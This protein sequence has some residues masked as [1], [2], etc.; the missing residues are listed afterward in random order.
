MDWFD[1]RAL[2]QSATIAGTVNIIQTG[3]Y[4][5]VGDF[6]GATYKRVASEPSHPGKVQSQD[7]AWWEQVFDDD[8]NV[9]QFGAVGD[10][11]TDD[12][13]AILDADAFVRTGK[14]TLNFYP[15]T[16][17]VDSLTLGGGAPWGE[18]NCTWRGV[19]YDGRGGQTN[20]ATLKLKDNATLGYLIGIAAG[21]GHYIFERFVMDGNKANQTQFSGVFRVLDLDPL[22]PGTYAYSAHL[23]FCHLFNGRNFG[24]YLGKNRGWTTAEDC[25]IQLNGI[26]AG[27]MGVVLDSY[28]CFFTRVHVGNNTGFGWKLDHVSQGM[29]S[30]CS[31]FMNGEGAVQITA[32]CTDFK[33]EGGSF[34]RN[35]KYGIVSARNTN[36]TYR[37]QR[38]F[39][40]VRF[41]GN[42]T[43]ADNTYSDVCCTDAED[44][45]SFVACDFMGWDNSLKRIKYYFDFANTGA[46]VFAQGCRFNKAAVPATGF[47]SAECLISE[48]YL[49]TEA[50]TLW[51]S[52]QT[53]TTARNDSNG[54]VVS[55]V[56]ARGSL[57]S[58]S[59]TQAWDT[60]LS[61]R[62][63]GYGASG[64]GSGGAAINIKSWQNWTDA[65][66]GSYV[67]IDLTP[68]NSATRSE[69]WIFRDDGLYYKGSK[70]LP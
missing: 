63:L 37:G 67:S 16:Y 14:G 64:Y 68:F 58:P 42:G 48:R 59:A 54:V 41:L 32:N 12:T 6:G 3:G 44:S 10:G 1:T 46:R 60:L 35:Q 9:H 34:D 38:L 8:V 70:V 24:F 56:K 4:A 36:P 51:N 50:S 45:L 30:D 2:V 23:R 40:G 52:C 28:D 22:P 69:V 43:A 31:S 18:K 25:D 19:G 66:Q 27:G 49:G 61:L 5:S 15:R 33:W 21:S 11:V 65:A 17:L 29:F 26:D 53:I 20:A 62:G 13:Q 57:D 39:T 7:G 47:M 55:G